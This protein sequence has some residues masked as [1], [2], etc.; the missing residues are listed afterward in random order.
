ME[1]NSKN[2]YPFLSISSNSQSNGF[3][4]DESGY[5]LLVENA[6]DAIFITIDGY[7]VFHNRKTEILTGYSSTELFKIPFTSFI[8]PDDRT[9]LVIKTNRE[10]NLSGF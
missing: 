9:K 10:H 7:I 8:Q 4:Q 2:S 3:F 6:N 5:R 1:K